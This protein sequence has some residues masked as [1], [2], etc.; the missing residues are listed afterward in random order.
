MLP[1]RFILLR[2]IYVQ[3]AQRQAMVRSREHMVRGSQR[4]SVRSK[5]GG[6]ALHVRQ[7]GDHRAAFSV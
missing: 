7:D 5:L 4:S 3:P 1:Q 2:Q 6:P